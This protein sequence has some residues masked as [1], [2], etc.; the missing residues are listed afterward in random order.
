MNKNNKEKTKKLDKSV[1]ES[2][3]LNDDQLEDIVGGAVNSIPLKQLDDKFDIS[4]QSSKIL[5]DHNKPE[6][7]L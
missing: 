7:F 3:K 6:N 2:S 4:P 5:P 1:D